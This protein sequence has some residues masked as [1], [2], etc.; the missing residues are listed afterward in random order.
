MYLEN[1][2]IVVKCK[3][4]KKITSK[5]KFH[6]FIVNQIFDFFIL[7]IF[8]QCQGIVELYEILSNITSA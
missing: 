2:S 7:M 5:F 8:S 1:R 6:G 3:Y 4:M